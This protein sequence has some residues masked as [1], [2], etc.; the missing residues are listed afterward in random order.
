MSNY[1]YVTLLTN[2][3]YMYG[4]TLLVE[5]MKRVDTKYPLHV[6]I[7]KDV[8]AASREMMDQLGVTYQHIDIIETPDF[9]YE[10]NLAIQPETAATWKNCWT[11][12]RIFDLTQFDKIVFL[13]ADVMIL[14]NLDHLFELPHLTAALDG[15]FFG[16][17]PGWPHFN[18]GCVVIEP[19][20]KTF[21]DIL[22][23][24]NSLTLEE[25]PDYIVAD[26]EVLNL[27]YKDWPE[28]EHL[29]LNKYY[30]IFAPYV[31]EEHLD[32]LKDNVYFIHYVGRKPWT[33]WLRNPVEVYTEY[34]Y[35]MGKNMIQD[36]VDTLDWDKIHE[37]VVVSVYGICK[38][39]IQSVENYINSFGEADYLC[40]LDTGSTDGTWEYLQ[41]AAST[42]PN[43]IIKQQEINPWRF[44][45]ARN[46]SMKLIPEETT[47]YFMAD[48]DEVI[49]EKGWVEKVRFSWSP[50]F[51]RG[52]Y[53]YNRDV[54][55]EDDTVIRAIKEYRVH[56]K[57][58]VRWV[59]IVHEAIVTNSGRKQFYIETCTPL[60]IVVWHYPTKNGR[61][62]NYME[63]CEADLVEH[64]ED[65][66]MHLQLAI[67]Y[68]LRQEKDKA[69]E[70]YLYLINNQNTLQDFEKGRCYYGIGLDLLRDGH[71]D[72]AMRFFF[73]GRLVAPGYAD[74]YLA[75]AEYYYNN[76][77]YQKAIDLCES[78]FQNCGIA[79]WCGVFDVNSFYP[80][81]LLAMNYYFLGN[82][83]KALAYMQIASIKSAQ[84]N[85]AQL[86]TEIAAEI[87]SEWKK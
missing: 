30:N 74:N 70:H 18:S 47:M 16:L 63:L 81:W 5:S 8:S 61:Q 40:I 33:F 72:K 35:E 73:E 17:W 27:Y 68:E 66:V 26:Q 53:T 46:E 21:E 37:K 52:M 34:Y 14:K 13:D 86:S 54:N 49:K 9:I 36:R 83:V 45:T 51:D 23:F 38:N 71:I 84:D 44:D 7:T 56:S 29:H 32:E 3:S 12:F 19:S 25:L 80:Y 65:W 41:E 24:G 87:C 31:L 20:H 79:P 43:M 77:K 75:P 85:I 22:S 4:V 57:S 6:L 1:S 55:Q 15:E 62:T 39:E 11:K 67:E 76:K 78:A 69:V 50:V 48:L 64:P 28:Q 2:D 42:H 60:D 10:H 58:W 59:N 82:K